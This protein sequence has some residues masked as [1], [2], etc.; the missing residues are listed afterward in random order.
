VAAAPWR[1]PL[2]IIGAGILIVWVLVIVAG[3]L[4]TSSGPLSPDYA[5][6]A[7]PS[8]SHPF[9]TDE[10]GRDILSRV[11]AGA[12][13][14]IPLAA[15]LVA[16]SVLVGGAVGAIAGYLGGWVDEIVMRVADLVFAFPTIILAMAVAAALGPSLRNAVLALVV[17]SWPGYARIVRSLIL[18][19]M[20]SEYVYVTR[21][22]GA[23]N[24]RILVVDVLPNIAGPVLVV[25][26]TDIGYAILQL[27]GLS[28]LGLGAKPPTPDWGAMIGDASNYFNA[29]WMGVFPGL[30]IFS[31]VAAFNFLGD[32][33]R[34]AID[35][36]T[37]RILRAT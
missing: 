10:I 6:L 36:R 29:W 21:L 14:S 2:A 34:D 18:T 27:A 32:S 16:L 3:P 26:A 11:I 4:L 17:V 22:I 24:A 33:L 12:R 13:L 19:A 30:A 20:Q 8:V 23:S 5:P 25:A 35:P 37:A 28:F 15:L 1:Q 7:R 9:G 31:V